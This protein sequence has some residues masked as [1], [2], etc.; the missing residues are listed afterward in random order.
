MFFVLLS[1]ALVQSS[2]SSKL[3]CLTVG[4]LSVV[5]FA[6]LRSGLLSKLAVRTR[7]IRLRTFQVDRTIL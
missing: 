5:M 1:A 6:Y 7:N 4:C 2:S 3:L